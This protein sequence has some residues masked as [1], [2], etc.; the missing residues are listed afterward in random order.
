[1]KPLVLQLVLYFGPT[2]GVTAFSLWGRGRFLGKSHI[3]QEIFI[4]T[5]LSYGLNYFFLSGIQ[6]QAIMNDAEKPSS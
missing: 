3:H 6:Y 1:M 4:A 2:L 5:H